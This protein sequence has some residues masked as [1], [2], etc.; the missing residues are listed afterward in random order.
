MKS[1]S[2]FSLRRIWTLTVHQLYVT[3]RSLEIFFDI[4]F[5]PLINVVLFG[6]I[7]QFVGEGVSN[8]QY[9]LLGVL[10]WEIVTI[11][12][13]N[14]TVSTMWE[15]WSHNLTNIFIAPISIL[16]YLLAHITAGII[17]TGSVMVMLSLAAVAFFNFNILDI[18]VVN[19]ILFA[20]NLTIF[21]IWVGILLLGFIFW[22]GTRMAAISW[23]LIFL[24]QPLT[25]AFFPLSVLPL[26]LQSIA[27][28]FPPTYVFEDARK[29][30]ADEKI[31]WN[32]SLRVLLANLVYLVLGA[33]I[34][35][36]LFEKSKQSGQFAR[37]DL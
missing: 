25:A 13:Y 23:G 29:A 32:S 22:F 19:L 30:L 14:I 7:S 26:W 8:K 36:W 34:F 18:G 12:Q 9:L 31:F 1:F 17:K 15:V 33:L 2:N 21:A 27:K 35:K 5:F 11:V 16:E 24:F 6:L 37:N 10:L 20:I 28:F 4:V 3:R